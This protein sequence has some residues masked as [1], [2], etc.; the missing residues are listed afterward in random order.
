M[1]EITVNISKEDSRIIMN[2]LMELPYKVSAETI[3]KLHVQ[4]VKQTTEQKVDN[5]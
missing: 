5:V 3:A 2:A 1:D 4:I